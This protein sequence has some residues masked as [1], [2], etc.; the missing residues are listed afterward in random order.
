MKQPS[1]LVTGFV[2]VVLVLLCSG[3]QRR[4]AAPPQQRQATPQQTAP[5]KPVAPPDAGSAVVEMPSLFWLPEDVKFPEMPPGSPRT[6]IL[7]GDPKAEGFYVTRTFIPK[8]KQVIP[9]THSDSRTVVVLSGTCYY[10]LGEEFNEDRMVALPPGSFFTEPAGVPHFTWAKEG[11]V[12]LQTTAVGPSGTQ[13]VPDK[14][15]NTS[16]K[17]P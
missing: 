11:D 1:F 7:L 2:A 8:G 16:P 15:P 3:Q 12:I 4:P 9:H 17:R 14:K 5:A 6:T 10:G 13:I